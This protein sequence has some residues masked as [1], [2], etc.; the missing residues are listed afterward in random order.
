MPRQTRYGATPLPRLMAARL[1]AAGFTDA[2]D[3][4]NVGAA[5][6]AEH[7]QAGKQGF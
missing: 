4:P 1:F 6:A 7:A 3:V 2:A 5:A